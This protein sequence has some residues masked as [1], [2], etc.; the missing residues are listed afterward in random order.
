MLPGLRP[1]TA[2]EVFLQRRQQDAT[3]A[4]EELTPQSS[5]VNKAPRPVAAAQADT[6]PTQQRR[7]LTRGEQ[8]SAQ[9]WGPPHSAPHGGAPERPPQL[10]PLH[11]SGSLPNSARAQETPRAKSGL[12]PQVVAALPGGRKASDGDL[13]A[14]AKP[15]TA[16]TTA[17]YGELATAAASLA[18]AAHKLARG[19]AADRSVAASYE[20]L[21]QA[22]ADLA[23]SAWLIRPLTSNLGG[24]GPKPTTPSPWHAPQQPLPTSL[25]RAVDPMASAAAAAGGGGSSTSGGG[26]AATAGLAFASGGAASAGASPS[27]RPFPGASPGRGRVHA[28]RFPGYNPLIHLMES[29]LP[30]PGSSGSAMRPPASSPITHQLQDSRTLRSSAGGESVVAGSPASPP[31]RSARGPGPGLGQRQRLPPPSDPRWAAGP[32]FSSGGTPPPPGLLLPSPYDLSRLPVL[33]LSADAAA[34]RFSAG[35]AGGD[36]WSSQQLMLEETERARGGGGG[37][38]GRLGGRLAD[39]Q[40]EST[41]LLPPNADSRT[42]EWVQ[43]A[44]AAAAAAAASTEPGITPYDMDQDEVDMRYN[45]VLEA[46]RQRMYARGPGRL[47]AAFRDLDSD[48]SGLL[49]RRD[50]LTVLQ[51]LNLGA[52][53]LLDEKVVDLMLSNV[54]A[55]TSSPRPNM[56]NNNNTTTNTNTGNGASQH[57]F[58]LNNNNT[59]SKHHH[60]PQSINQPNPPNELQQQQNQ[61]PLQPPQRVPY[62]DFVNALRFGSLPWRGYNPRLRHRVGADPDQPFGPPSALAGPLPYGTVYGADGA[63]AAAAAAAAAS[64]VGGGGGGGINGGSAPGA[65]GGVPSL[66]TGSKP[67]ADLSRGSFR[68]ADRGAEGGLTL[69]AVDPLVRNSADHQANLAPAS[70]GGGNDISNTV[71]ATTAPATVNGTNPNGSSPPRGLRGPTLPDFQ[72]QPKLE[73]NNAGGLQVATTGSRPWP[74]ASWDA[75]MSSS[76]YYGNGGAGGG[77]GSNSNS[78]GNSINGNAGVHGSSSSSSWRPAQQQQQQQ[79]LLPPPQPA[80]AVLSASSRGVPRQHP[81]PLHHQQQHPQQHQQHPAPPGGQQQTPHPQP[82]QQQQLQQQRQ[83]GWVEELQPWGHAEGSNSS[84]PAVGGGAAAGGLHGSSAGP[85]GGDWGSSST[86]GG[87]GGAAGAAAA[88]WQGAST[89]AWVP[90]ARVEPLSGT[91]AGAAAVLHRLSGA[92]GTPLVGGGRASRV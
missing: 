8:P 53:G 89:W 60:Q 27:G 61:H 24:S 92:P 30:L 86:A 48:G 69:Q 83:P 21:A 9:P 3:E 11:P 59:N 64:A 50:F 13:P 46:L 37:G 77:G 5:R 38:G 79:H 42:A 65:A 20:T 67:P 23:T 56:N 10:H 15:T 28:P 82:Q 39:E 12:T 31:L 91:H 33:S 75:T 78:G 45:K 76:Y 90:A 80:G 22:A 44:A 4:H 25:P 62:S 63:A 29:E 19:S 57:P 14:A 58:Y 68:Q 17:V 87:A 47:A 16:G 85:Q 26:G 70:H 66:P 18:S 52:P 51:G 41:S 84:Y 49:S 43:Q 2:F 34:Q 81:F 6:P 32:T 55:A 7:T 71:T 54:A 72:P 1:L 35:A 73:V 40:P 36:V 74:T 88:S